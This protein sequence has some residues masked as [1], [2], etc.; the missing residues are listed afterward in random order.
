VVEICDVAPRDGLQSA[1]VLWPVEDKLELIRRLV[2]AGVRRLEVASFVNPHRVPAMADA[3]AVCAGLPRVPGVRYVGL[4]LN[5][6]GMD[7]AVA[8]G[9]NEVN[10]AVACTDSFAQRNQGTTAAGS[11]EVWRRVAER[12]QEEGMAAQVVLSTAFGC[13]YEGEVPLERVVQVAQACAA[14]GPVRL[15]LADTIGSAAPA[16]VDAR[17]AAV[18]AILPAGTELALHLHNSRG[19]AAA[20]AW[21]AYGLGV[22]SFDA[23]LAGIGGCPFAPGASGNVC[24]EDLAYLFERSGVITGLDLDELIRA[25]RWLSDRVGAPTPG[26][27]AKAGPFPRREVS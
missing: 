7:R 15:T 16:D 24:T 4:V 11:V 12:A 6:R 21:V 17:V 26:A 13:P 27:Y 1:S 19:T 23:S 5:E 10:A 2:A 3:E 20:N 9:V 18:Q 8:A 25:S 22:R 14:A